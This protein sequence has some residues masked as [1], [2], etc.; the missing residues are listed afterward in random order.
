MRVL[1]VDDEP[2]LTGA[3]VALLERHGFAAEAVDT[4]EAALAAVA[5]R[6]PDLVLLDVALPGLD[7]LEVCRQLR[8][9]HRY[10][11]VVLLTGR[12]SAAD[13]LAGFAALADDYV[14]KPASPEM[15]LARVRAVLRLARATDPARAVRRF[16]EVEVDLAAR[17]VRRGGQPVTLTRREFSL[18]AFLLEHPGQTFGRTQ[19]LA[20][21]WGS[22]YDGGTE[23]VTQHVS[24]L[25]SALEP[26]P[27]RP[28][29]LLTR[30]GVGYLFARPAP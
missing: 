11:P 12:A 8:L 14:V 10:L 7:G 17:A 4:G 24:R 25:R 2:A 9:R 1:V 3:V 29:Y 16:G 23:T 15:L 30:P 28:R 18:L 27:N 22:D 5:E 26:N 13:E 19:L 6:P 20:Q 21:V